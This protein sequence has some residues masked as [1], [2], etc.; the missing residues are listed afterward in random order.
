[1]KKEEFSSKNVIKKIEGKK[2]EIL[3]HGVKKIGIFGSIVRGEQKNNS[4]IDILIVMD[5]P[6]FDKY[7][8]L[9]AMFERLFKKKVDLVIEDDLKPE[10][11]YV[12][13]EAKYA[14][15]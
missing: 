4:D 3:K 7:M 13:K 11:K 9:K 2:K 10:L 8:D 1:M 15:L 14:K 5:N 6:T 12:K